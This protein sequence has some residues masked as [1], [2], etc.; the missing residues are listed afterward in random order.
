MDKKIDDSTL[1]ISTE[2]TAWH[3]VGQLLFRRKE[4]EQQL[5]KVNDLLARAEA[6]GIVIDLGEKQ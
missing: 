6:V 3:S 2:S 4:L 5:Q 1:E